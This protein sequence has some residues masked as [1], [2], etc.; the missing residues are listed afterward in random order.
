MLTRL[1][2]GILLS[3]P[4]RV[5]SPSQSERYSNAFFL[6]PDFDEIITPNANCITQSGRPAQ[7]ENI[8]Y[9]EYIQVIY[10]QNYQS[11]TDNNT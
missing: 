2:N 3:T 6:Q 4:H 5:I 9:R 1:S 11:H 8:T 7:Y 10:K